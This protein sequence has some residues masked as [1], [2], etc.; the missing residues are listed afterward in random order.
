MVVVLMNINKVV[1]FV[2]GLF[3]DIGISLILEFGPILTT[4]FALLYIMFYIP[5]IYK[6]I[7]NN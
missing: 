6:Y 4:I 5:D 2:I 7:K 1:K 3:I